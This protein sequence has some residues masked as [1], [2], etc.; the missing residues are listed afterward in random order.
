MT[1][2]AGFDITATYASGDLVTTNGSWA[3]KAGALVCAEIEKLA[4]TKL[5]PTKTIRLTVNIRHH[6]PFDCC[7]GNSQ[8]ELCASTSRYYMFVK[9]YSNRGLPCAI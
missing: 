2:K 7:L 9:Y 4:I 5:H 6:I 8:P 3:G 1:F